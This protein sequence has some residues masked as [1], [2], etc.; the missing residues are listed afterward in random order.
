M[1]ASCPQ[2]LALK[3]FKAVQKINPSAAG[4]VA[5]RGEHTGLAVINKLADQ[6]APDR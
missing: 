6:F 4:T 2:P 3:S 1:L 5:P